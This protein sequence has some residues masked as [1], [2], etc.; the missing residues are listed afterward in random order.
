M[1]ARETSLPGVVV[2]ESPVHADSRGDF[3]E[4]HHARKFAA[5]GLPSSFEQD[6]LSRS[7]QGTLRGI[8]YQLQS[9]QG[10]LVRPISGRI[11][12]VAVDLRR[13]SA[14]FGHWVGIELE[15]GDGRAV[16]VPPGFGHGFLVLSPRADVFYKCTTTYDP[17]SDRG[18]RWNDEAL[19]I[20]WP[21]V[22]GREP[23]LS[24]KDRAAPTFRN[25]ELFP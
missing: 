7:V 9:P 15:A 5:I 19:A 14:T 2:V 24:E 25:A 16:W 17:S 12:D 21:L 22:D 10:K 1:K 18:I 8:H 20:D 4:V 11:F 23:L 3:S 13:S 6:N